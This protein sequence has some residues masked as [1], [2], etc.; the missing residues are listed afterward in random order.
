E[1]RAAFN[2]PFWPHILVT[3][4]VGQ[5]GLDFHS[6]CD[7]LGHWD[8]CSSPVDLEQRE[9]RIQR[10]GGLTVRRPLAQ[11][12]GKTALDEARERGSSPWDVIARE[13]DR[14]YGD[15]TGMSPWWTMPNAEIKRH[16]FA[17]PQSRDVRRFARLRN[18][19]LLYRLAMGQ[20]DQEDLVNL[21]ASHDS[22]SA[23]QLR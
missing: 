16:L 23:K 22:E 6:W 18:Q 19:R 4:S 12:L 7:R 20:P 10:F 15:D 14:S 5:E 1:I 21:L 9:G 17:L 2:T 3:T 13:A 8:L 11:A